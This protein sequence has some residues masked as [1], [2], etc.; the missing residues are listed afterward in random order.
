MTKVTYFNL[1][2]DMNVFF[3]DSIESGISGLAKIKLLYFFLSIFV[4]LHCLIMSIPPIQFIM[5]HS[6]P[7]NAT[8]VIKTVL[9]KQIEM[10]THRHESEHFKESSTVLYTFSG[11]CMPGFTGLFPIF[12][13][14]WGFF[15]LK[16]KLQLLL[17]LSFFSVFCLL[18]K[19][20][21][22]A[23]P[24]YHESVILLLR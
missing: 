23:V 22:L 5:L 11:W 12:V 15:F 24:T 18:A 1:K 10:I 3:L 14:F 21:S 16:K 6:E 8:L 19:I 4:A 9:N 13:E 20:D 17:F 2:W 7:S